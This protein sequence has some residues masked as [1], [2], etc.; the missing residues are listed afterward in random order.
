MTRLLFF[1][2]PSGALFQV[3]TGRGRFLVYIH[4]AER[5]YWVNDLSGAQM[6]MGYLKGVG[7]CMRHPEGR[8][9]S[10][11]RFNP[12]QQDQELGYLTLRTAI[13]IADLWFSAPGCSPVIARRL[14]CLLGWILSSIS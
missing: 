13:E 14:V 6:G 2:E 1:G 12:S 11:S 3:F 8:Y 10:L 7:Q 9:L 5:V 4:D